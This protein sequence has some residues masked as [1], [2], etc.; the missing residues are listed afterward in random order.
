MVF[1][2][3]ACNA[4]IRAFAPVILSF[5]FL[6]DY[7]DSTFIGTAHTLCIGT[8]SLADYAMALQGLLWACC[9]FL[10]VEFYVDRATGD[11]DDDDVA[12]LHLTYIA[13]VGCLW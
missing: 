4:R 10:V 13:S 1:T 7:S 3:S 12:I 6:F 2:P 8:Q 5:I 11:V 9:Q